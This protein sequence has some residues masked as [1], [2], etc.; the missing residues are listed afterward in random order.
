MITN[1]LLT[2][3]TVD[4]LWGDKMG[5][6]KVSQGGRVT[7]E[8]IYLF[9]VTACVN[10]MCSFPGAIYLCFLKQ[11]V[12]PAQNSLIQLAWLVSQFL[13]PCI[14]AFISSS[15]YKFR[16]PCTSFSVLFACFV[17]VVWCEDQTQVL[18]LVRQQALC[19]LRPTPSPL[20]TI[21]MGSGMQRLVTTSSLSHSHSPN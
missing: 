20:C 17:C 12:W 8:I 21:E 9:C 19:Q 6:S 10:I 16:T 7:S 13:R 3:Y 4:L 1:S 14:S 15:G 11:G 5:F 2:C 18:L